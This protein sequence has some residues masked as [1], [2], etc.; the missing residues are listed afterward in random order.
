MMPTVTL[1]RSRDETLDLV[2]AAFERTDGI[3]A[4][5]VEDDRVVGKTGVRLF[6]WGERV[7]VDLTERGPE[8]TELSVE[9][10]REVSFNITANA[11]KFESR[12][13][14]ALAAL[15]D[16]TEQPATTQTT[17]ETKEAP[18][19]E[20][21]PAGTRSMVLFVVLFIPAVTVPWFFIG[22]DFGFNVV[23]EFVPSIVVMV[24]WYLLVA[25]V[26]YLALWYY[27]GTFWQ[28]LPT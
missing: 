26:A 25:T 14:D 21:L 2:T 23:E 6:S 11:P 20:A 17:S 10:D 3:R 16:G 12:F 19:A 18:S 1:D 7:V 22:T 9:A 27:E 8:T 13:L 5:H 28:R 24:A 15:R 4:Y